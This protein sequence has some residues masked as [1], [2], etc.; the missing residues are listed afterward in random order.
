MS[1]LNFARLFL[2]ADV[3]VR[4]I[5]KKFED[6]RDVTTLKVFTI[7]GRFSEGIPETDSGLNF[8]IGKIV[9]GSSL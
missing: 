5:K 2:D 3:R 1:I 4:S 9:Q 8:R 6:L 7:S